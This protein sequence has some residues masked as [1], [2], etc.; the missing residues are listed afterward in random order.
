M[1][2]VCEFLM[3]LFILVGFKSRIN[4][5]KFGFLFTHPRLKD[6]V[7]LYNTVFN[8]HSFILWQF[9]SICDKNK[10]AK[11]DFAL[12]GAKVWQCIWYFDFPCNK[13][14]YECY[15]DN[16]THDEADDETPVEGMAKVADSGPVTKVVEEYVNEINLQFKNN[17]VSLNT[18][19]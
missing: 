19:G 10:H 13:T 16:V 7:I 12:Y 18:I 15:A 8:V 17:F 14:L 3:Y 1:L 6:N 9:N 2:Y 4:F 5:N 11:I